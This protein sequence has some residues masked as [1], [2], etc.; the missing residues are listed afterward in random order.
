[1][2]D[3]AGISRPPGAATAPLRAPEGVASSA[4]ASVAI[5]R[6][7]DGDLLGDAGLGPDPGHALAELVTGYD[8][9]A[10]GAMIERAYRVAERA[11]S[12]QKRD[13]GDPYIGHPVA[14]AGILAGYRLD[15]ATI[16]TALLHD[17]VEDTGLTLADLSRDFGP[18][19]AKLVD[20]VT[21]LT[22]LE[23]QSERTKQ[24]E[25]FRKLVLA[26]SEDIRVLLVKLADRTHNMRTLH[27]VPQQHR[28]QKTARETMEIYAP[29]A[30]RI[31]M[32]AVKD[33]LEDRSFRELQPDAAQT[34]HAR[35]AFLRGQ[36][37]DLI[38]EI[39]EDIRR[40]LRD[41][42]VPVIDIQGREKSAYGIWLKMHSKKVEF[43]QLSDIMAFRIVTDD[44]ANCYAALG[45][46]HS[47]YRVVPGRFK[48]Y[49]STPKPNG[50]QSLHT[51]VTVPER[52]N[53]KIEVQIRTPEM[54]EVAE[55]GVA[56]HW[57]YKQ[58]PDG[59]V[60]AARDR[61]R[62]PWVK[63]LLEILETAGEA[64]DFL[65]NTKLALHQDQ[66]FCF[67]PKGDLIALPRGATPVD[68]A[69]QVHSQVGDSTVGA[70]IN[71]RIV[72]LR[73]QLENGDQVEI[74]TARGGTPNP[75][76]ERFVV[77]G[78]ARARIRR[79]VLARQREESRE[80]GRQAIARAFRQE[81]LD[82]S[83]RTA[84]PAVRALKQPGFEELCIAVGN[85]N[86]TAR[87][88]L[89]AAVPELRGAA[90]PAV[91][92][93]E[94]LALTRARG[95][96]G[97]TVPYS[98][99]AGGREVAHGITGL[100][101]GME[102]HFAN[103]CHPVPGDR[104]VGIIST[105]RGV[106]VHKQGCHTLEAFSATPERFIDVDWDG[107]PG[108]AGEHVARLSVVT[109]NE[110]PA[111]AGMTTAIAKQEARI[112]SLR[113]LHRAADFAE[114]NVDLEVKDLR[115]LSSVIAALRALPGIEQVERAKA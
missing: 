101:S 76:W 85:G 12:A 89:H 72:P 51:G 39:K 13:N 69:Y 46:V 50:Y 70:K 21:K 105:G 28:R 68:F 16:A 15:A 78:K 31:G 58:G 30:E 84:E 92:G 41:A 2:T 26:M 71:G 97:A 42:E 29:L 59:V 113:F 98:R 20:G 57:I 65:E 38:E 61:K 83:E 74:I 11:H 4:P 56:A 102:V 91:S 40:R 24:A 3:G 77:T 55:F 22:R 17:T 87:D 90:R 36:G 45:A 9:R 48:D 27:F 112:Q 47:A 37:A 63:D 6:P 94:A 19:I 8:P 67:T 106:T 54:H 115:H 53:A 62:F 96:P 10:D 66:V 100:V 5:G 110:G 114:L 43:E 1:M 64:Q 34:I 32:Q 52:R 25:N 95:K 14:V 93:I 80:N 109:S 44:K 73:Y 103:C 108:A 33:E 88:V 99:G 18:E 35:L 23:L 111:I 104:I 75:A 82:F 60:N 49:I 81:G 79:T 107:G 7:P 86:V